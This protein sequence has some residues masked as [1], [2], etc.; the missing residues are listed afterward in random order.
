MPCMVTMRRAL[1]EFCIERSIGIDSPLAIDAAQR[2]VGFSCHDLT[3]TQLR[4][5]LEQWYREL[6]SQEAVRASAG[7]KASMM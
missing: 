1:D 2:I 6:Q 5:E 4:H 7:H 3:S